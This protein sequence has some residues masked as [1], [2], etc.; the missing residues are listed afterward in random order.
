MTDP[1]LG[2]FGFF[3]QYTAGCSDPGILVRGLGRQFWGE[4]YFKPYPACMATHVT[5]EA[6]RAATRG[7][8]LSPEQVES[9]VVR[10]PAPSLANFCGKPYEPRVCAH[11]DAIFSYRHMVA[12]VLLSGGVAQEH[13]AE[14]RLREPALLALA[15]R[16]QLE[17]LGAG[18]TGAQVE[19]ILRDGT[20]GAGDAPAPSRSPLVQHASV[21]EIERKFR[22]QVEFSE[23][24]DEADTDRLHALVA[25][26]DQQVSV[27]AI[28]GLLAGSGAGAA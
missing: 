6:A 23:L 10:L 25:T 5:I 12:R 15:Q 19:V 4:A 18:R 1:L 24:L 13:Y 11:A 17:P 3:K 7:R 16:V 22:R 26:L 27:G 21:D 14:D 9:V 2:R 20:R 8:P 28:A